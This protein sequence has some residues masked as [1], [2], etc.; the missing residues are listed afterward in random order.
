MVNVKN[1]AIGVILT[2]IAIIVVF[3]LVGNSSDD[4]VA[5]SG[6][7][8]ASGLPL[9]SLFES[10]GVVMLIFM[11]GILIMIVGMALGK[12]QKQ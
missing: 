8:S 7:I 9:A 3:Q 4:L 2:I 6:N 5:A 10:S 11:A 1:A 12:M